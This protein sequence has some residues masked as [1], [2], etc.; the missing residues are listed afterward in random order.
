MTYIEFDC[1]RCGQHINGSIDEFHLDKSI[2]I[3]SGFYDLTKGG[4]EQF[5]RSPLENRI[6]DAC[7]HSDHL[8][9]KI[10]ATCK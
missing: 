8:Y 7:M 6:C 2:K 5:S 4:W 3:T 1:D 10:Y 9:K